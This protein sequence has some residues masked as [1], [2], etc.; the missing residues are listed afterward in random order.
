MKQK[1]IVAVTG[2]SG[3]IYAEVLLERLN[4]IKK[5]ISSCSLILSENAKKVWQYELDN[6][7]FNKYNF[8]FY[9][10]TDLF[11]PP[12]SGSSRFDIMIIAPC[13]MATLGKIANGISN[14]LITR[15]ADVMIKERQKLILLTREMP[16]SPVHINNMK[17]L[18]DAGVIICPASP[19]FY[20]KPVNIK[21]LIY[22]VVDKVLLLAGFSVNS[23]NWGEK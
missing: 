1:I 19:S 11:A 16:L 17:T 14:N 3:S 7:E 6:S 9:E 21:Q 18:T 13:S 2:A 20:S 4:L 23:F 12:A 10:N 22:T 15:A 8:L 5:Q